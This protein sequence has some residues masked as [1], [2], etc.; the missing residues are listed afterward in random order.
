MSPL[1]IGLFTAVLAACAC[2][3]PRVSPATSAEPEPRAH[4]SVEFAEWGPA[5]FERAAAQDKLILINV[6]ATWCH[7]CHVMD[8][9][10]FANPEVAALLAKHFVV[11]RVDSDA[12]PDL[13]E[14][15][16]AWGWPATAFLSPQA[17]P[18]LNLRGYRDPSV[19]A[20]LLREL[21]AEH[22]RGE[23]RSFAPRAPSKAPADT[24]LEHIRELASAQLDAYF[25]VD[26]L[27]WGGNQ[28]YPW[29]EPIEYAF[30][31]ARVHG[32]ELWQPRA[33]ATL[34]AQRALIDPVAGGMYQYS[35][36][37]RWDRPHFEKIAMI[38]AGA[39]ETYAHAAMITHDPQ[40]LEPARDVARYLLDTMQDPRGGFFSSQDADLR[41]TDG[42]TVVGAD[43]YALDAAGRRALGSPRIDTAIYADLNGRMIHALTELYR[44]G[45]DEQVRAA[46]IRAGERLLATH[47]RESG[48]FSHAP[49]AS[50][51]G[52]VHLA[53]QAAVGWAFVGLHRVTADRRWRDEALA[54][55]GFM[56]AQLG[57]ADGGYYAHSKDP[58]AVGIF[59]ER[60]KPLR[61]NALAAQ[62]LLELDALGPPDP[63]AES[64]L[65]A[66]A[67]AT[68][69]AVGSDAQIESSGK[70]L[71]RYLVALALDQ[72]TRFDITIVAAPG[73][74]TG[75]ALW[76]AALALWEP[77]ATI[78][79][80]EPGQR[81]PEIGEPA[82][83]LCSD[84]ACSRPITDP[85]RLAAIAESFT[86]STQ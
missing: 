46:A 84:R 66:R 58:S 62:F 28:K 37:G 5:S 53:D 25:D 18:V 40:W 35:L 78:E 48:G 11:I 4:A 56:D 79:R 13:S 19:F 68:L 82:A 51:D 65:R 72:A 71:G 20:A 86:A 14:R 59:A 6:I 47:E 17:E 30:V 67:H 22:Q 27:G 75:D 9:V 70:I 10:T 43:Y 39:I 63:A 41:R 83:Y 55:A 7:W 1:R 61:E 32:D 3:G 57:A 85:E 73:N 50:V 42:T 80:S 26:A 69:L 77:R 8:E 15:Y 16:R 33:L 54:I 23:L 29:P 38:Q 52:L 76:R 74:S 31:R 49:D 81:Y 2:A 60:R 12:R 36:G 34:D 64:S 21:I 45:G 24:D 44:A